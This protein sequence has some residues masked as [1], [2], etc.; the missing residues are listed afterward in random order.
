MIKP[1]YSCNQYIY[2]WCYNDHS[3]K[4]LISD[5]LTRQLKRHF[6]ET[7]FLITF[8]FLFSYFSFSSVKCYPFTWSEQ[9]WEW[10]WSC[11][12]QFNTK[13]RTL[14]HPGELSNAK[15]STTGS[16]TVSAES[17]TLQEDLKL[18]KLQL[19]FKPNPSV[20]SSVGSLLNNQVSVHMVYSDT[21]KYLYYF[22][23]V[24]VKE[25]WMLTQIIG[26]CLGHKDSVD[27]GMS[28]MLKPILHFSHHVSW[29]RGLLI[30]Q[31]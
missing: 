22:Y 26:A 28:T 15:I 20:N 24:K 5:H 2:L 17:V 18:F 1:N 11:Y 30:S 31:Q 7:H 8:L 29:N 13:L 25:K 9:M 12:P 27:A 6:G 19:M 21:V 3:W 10:H 4:T 23:Q 16:S 14:T